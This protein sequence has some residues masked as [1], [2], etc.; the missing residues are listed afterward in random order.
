MKSL[1]ILL[2]GL[3]LLTLC[4]GAVGSFFIFLFDVIRWH[5]AEKRVIV[6]ASAQE[7]PDELTKEVNSDERDNNGSSDRSFE[8]GADRS[9]NGT[10]AGSSD[11]DSDRDS[12]SG[13]SSDAG[14][15]SRERDSRFIFDS[16]LQ[17]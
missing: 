14:T 2:V 1:L 7:L 8:R 13:S 4:C 9:C 17:S 6:S 3:F 12:G 10:D 15:E 11:G 5:R 16:W